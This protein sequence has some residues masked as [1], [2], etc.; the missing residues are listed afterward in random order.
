VRTV[1]IEAARALAGTDLLSLP[2]ELQTAL[3][4]ATKELVAIGPGQRV[5]ARTDWL[6]RWGTLRLPIFAKTGT[7]HSPPAYLPAE[8]ILLFLLGHCPPDALRRLPHSSSSRASAS[9]CRAASR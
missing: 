9:C 8:M 3:V 7:I 5:H 4:N 6:C 2:P 1:R